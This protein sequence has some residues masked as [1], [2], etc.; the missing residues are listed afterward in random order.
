MVFGRSN[1]KICFCTIWLSLKVNHNNNTVSAMLPISYHQYN[2]ANALL[3]VSCSQCRS[4]SPK[5][6]KIT[7][8]NSNV[9]TISYCS[10]GS[11][12]QPVTG[13]LVTEQPESDV[14]CHPQFVN[15]KWSF[16]MKLSWGSL[17][18]AFSWLSL[19]NVHMNVCV[20]TNM[21]ERWTCLHERM[22]ICK[23]T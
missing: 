2:A 14:E 15:H 7:V 16:I 9:F 6:K 11:T 22:Q 19:W 21:L 3:P 12:G 1:E 23:N 13:Q 4:C 8:L 10:A 5:A 17:S 20:C 18:L